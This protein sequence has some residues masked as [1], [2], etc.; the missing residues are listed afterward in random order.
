MTLIQLLCCSVASEQKLP[1]ATKSFCAEFAEAAFPDLERHASF[2]ECVEEYCQ[3]KQKHFLEWHLTAKH[4]T[5]HVSYIY[6]DPHAGSQ[7]SPL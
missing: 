2:A 1:A 6:T 5:T 4:H 7:L 3:A